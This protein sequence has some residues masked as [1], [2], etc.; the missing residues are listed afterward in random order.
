MV[1][2]GGKMADALY[3]IA[4]RDCCVVCRSAVPTEVNSAIM[5]LW[6]EGRSPDFNTEVFVC[7]LTYQRLLNLGCFWL[8]KG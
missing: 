6:F 3:R 5:M 2:M 4:A 7:P 8:S 1:Y